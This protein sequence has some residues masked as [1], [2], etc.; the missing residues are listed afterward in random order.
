MLEDIPPVKTTTEILR[1]E[2][3]ENRRV[4]ALGG[5][6]NKTAE[7]LKGKSILQTQQLA[8]HRELIIHGLHHPSLWPSCPSFRSLK[9]R[10]HHFNDSASTPLHPH[11]SACAPAHCKLG[12]YN[13]PARPH[14]RPPGCTWRKKHTAWLTPLNKLLK[15]S[16]SPTALPE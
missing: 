12:K 11:P 8:P 14:L 2:E 6:K 1:T 3:E 13:S 7:I 4:S 15:P 16:P 10:L 9:S 5:E